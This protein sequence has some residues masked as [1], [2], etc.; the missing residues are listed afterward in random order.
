MRDC[1]D[2]RESMYD[3][4]DVHHQRPEVPIGR[5]LDPCFSEDARNE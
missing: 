5:V 4:P 3:V 2:E 1:C